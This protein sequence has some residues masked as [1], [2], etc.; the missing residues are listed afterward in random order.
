MS[1]L[2]ALASLALAS[3]A[4]S[5]EE[6]TQRSLQDAT[7]VAR[8]VSS[9]QR[10]LGKINRD[11]GNSYRFDTTTVR[12]KEPFKLRLEAAV[13]DTN[14]LYI[15]NGPRQL[16]K[17]RQIHSVQDL[18]GKPGRRQTMLDFGILTPSLFSSLFEA[19]FVRNDRATGNV[20]FD[21][22]Y[23]ARLDDTS[24]HRIWVDAERKI[25]TKREWYN[26]YGRLMAT[27]LYLSPKLEGGVWM[28][29]RLEVKNIDGAIAGITR[30]DSIKVNTGLSDSLFEVR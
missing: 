30:Y 2:I 17:I 16:I 22:T 11:F 19:K 20:V 23:P 9:N 1:T 6:Y 21:L 25:V 14:V 7:F 12:V 27:F 5:I 8:V 13:E 24:R 26:Q 29:T 28:P 3:P 18:T 15:I 4:V 10:E